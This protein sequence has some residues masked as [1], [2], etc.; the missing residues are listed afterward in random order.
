MRRA[1]NLAL[2]MEADLANVHTPIL[3]QVG[4]GGVNDCDVIFFITY[5]NK[6]SR[7]I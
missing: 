6:G 1:A 3:F 4:P 2:I 5:N 7:Q